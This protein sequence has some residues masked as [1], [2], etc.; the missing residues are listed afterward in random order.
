M[1][2][3]A[4]SQGGVLYCHCLHTLSVGSCGCEVVDEDHQ[5]DHSRSGVEGDP[6]HCCQEVESVDESRAVG[7]HDCNV[8]LILVLGDFCE[9]SPSFPALDIMPGVDTLGRTEWENE[10]LSVRAAERLCSCRP[11]PDRRRSQAVPLYLRHLV[12]LV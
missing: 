6:C 12:F 9:T 3:A 4:T 1:A 5:A 10:T 8:E 2:I 11:P 7:P